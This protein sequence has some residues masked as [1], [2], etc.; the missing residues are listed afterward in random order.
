MSSINQN[1]E[2]FRLWLESQPED[3][4]AIAGDP[5]CCWLAEW[6]ESQGHFVYGVFPQHR[7]ER[8]S[9][10]PA[11]ASREVLLE[12]PDEEDEVPKSDCVA[13]E[14]WAC[15]F[16]CEVDQRYHE[17]SGFSPVS[18]NQALEVFSAIAF[19]KYEVVA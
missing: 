12:E 10:A 16:A 3:A 15:E 14:D 11:A 18:R 2:D 7:L 19:T 4:F 6:F 5:N 1:K 9:D 13:L 8:L 17:P